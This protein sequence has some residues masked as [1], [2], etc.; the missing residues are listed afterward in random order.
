MQSVKSNEA[1]IFTAGKNISP[2]NLKEERNWVM[3]ESIKWT[4]AIPRRVLA[5]IR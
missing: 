5:A 3:I 2:L 1:K 4:V